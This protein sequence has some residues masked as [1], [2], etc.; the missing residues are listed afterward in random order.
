MSIAAE[1]IVSVNDH[2]DAAQHALKRLYDMNANKLFGLSWEAFCLKYFGKKRQWLYRQLW[3]AEGLDK[4]K[5]LKNVSHVLQSNAALIA[6]RDV[7][8]ELTQQVY[9]AATLH[10]T[11]VLTAPKIKS[12][13]EC[14]SQTIATG[15]V[16]LADGTQQPVVEA[17]AERVQA[18]AREAV[19]AKRDYIVAGVPVMP[20]GYS[21]NGHATVTLEITC[22]DCERLMTS[23]PL[24]GTIWIDLEDHD[25]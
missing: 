21:E 20:M 12:A 23:S 18:E 17:V 16:E 8:D 11:N 22:A 4:L 2:L 5:A 7:P 13:L 25:G 19:L 14:F 15:A 10:G 3:A 6:F 9:N 24:R 1:L